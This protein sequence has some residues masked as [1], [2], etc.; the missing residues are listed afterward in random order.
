MS[1]F[2]LIVV[3]LLEQLKPLDYRRWVVRP[4]GVWADFWER[5]LNA[6]DYRHGVPGV[7]LVLLPPLALGGVVW[8]LAYWA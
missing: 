4:F 7:C 3:F 6:G 1:L 2:S 8:G 5:R